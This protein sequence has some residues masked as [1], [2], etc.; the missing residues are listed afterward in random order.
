MHTIIPMRPE[1]CSLKPSTPKSIVSFFYWSQK[2]MF[3]KTIFPKYVMESRFFLAFLAPQKKS[4]YFFCDFE[5]FFLSN[6]QKF[7]LKKLISSKNPTRRLTFYAIESRD[8]FWVNFGIQ[9]RPNSS[10][11]TYGFSNV[12]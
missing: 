11:L 6:G 10:T 7:L 1:L 8:N 12:L 4:I 2:F 3:E 5:N 9:K